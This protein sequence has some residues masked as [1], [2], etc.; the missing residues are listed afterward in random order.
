MSEVLR[1]T[2]KTK[3]PAGAFSETSA[4]LDVTVS[5]A[6]FALVTVTIVVTSGNPVA[7]AMIVTVASL[8]AI[9]SLT[10]EM[11]TFSD[12]LP[13]GNVTVAG[14]SACVILEDDRLTIRGDVVGPVRVTVNVDADAPAVSAKV[15][16]LAV[17]VNTACRSV[18][19]I[20][21][22][23]GANPVAAAV[24][25]TTTGPVAAGLFTAAIPTLAVVLPAGI[26]TD[27]GTVA[28]EGFDEVSVTT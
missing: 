26:V 28:A 18:T 14:T 16:G 20:A 8:F 24:I 5:V 27:A 17:S 7:E 15:A 23:A 1:L 9:L 2:V 6:T 21:V 4:A 10:A 22:V 12:A 19:V 3:V 13:I 11:N 25:V